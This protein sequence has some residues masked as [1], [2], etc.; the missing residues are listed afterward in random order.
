M[1]ETTKVVGELIR[2]CVRLN[3]SNRKPIK[4]T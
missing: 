1:H 3:P 4:V 2:V